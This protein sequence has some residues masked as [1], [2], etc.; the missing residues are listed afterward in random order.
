MEEDKKDEEKKLDLNMM[1]GIFQNNR[2]MKTIIE[3]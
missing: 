2:K 3:S 1:R